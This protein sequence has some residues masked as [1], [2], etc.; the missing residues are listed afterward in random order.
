MLV[1]GC[2]VNFDE[3]GDGGKLTYRD[4]V[5][6]DSPAGYWRLGDSSS[7]AKDET[8]QADGTYV[9]TCEH[10]VAGALAGDADTATRF[11][12]ST[13]QVQLSNHYTYAGTS[14]FTIELWGNEAEVGVYQHFF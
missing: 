8:G 10:G 3:L 14:A 6:A 5:L 4:A 11:D 12:G 9:G 13:C 2:R 1:V 7:V